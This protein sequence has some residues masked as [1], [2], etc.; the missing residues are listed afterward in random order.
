MIAVDVQTSPEFRAGT[1]KILFEGTFGNSFDV[2]SDGKRFLMIKPPAI[3]QRS[4]D[5]V[6]VVL[7]W[8]DELRRRVP[9]TK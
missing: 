7:N 1:P 2:T 3:V 4:A 5:Q 6:T 9:T 8:F